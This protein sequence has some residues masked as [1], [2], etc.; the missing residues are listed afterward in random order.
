MKL[1]VI[2]VLFVIM[3]GLAWCQMGSL[4]SSLSTGEEKAQSEHVDQVSLGQS[5][6]LAGNGQPNGFS[7][8]EKHVEIGGPVQQTHQRMDNIELLIQK[9]KSKVTNPFLKDN[10]NLENISNLIANFMSGNQFVNNLEVKGV[11]ELTNAN[12]KEN[13]NSKSISTKK[14]RTDEINMKD[15][16][17]SNEEISLSPE[18]IL[19]LKDSK[20]VIFL[21]FRILK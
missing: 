15:I 12:L 18:T 20:M 9:M 2:C 10:L 6:G 4:F 16:I 14:L 13:L 7:F 11:A 5:M 1:K 3:N 19:K 21:I 8:A 17:L